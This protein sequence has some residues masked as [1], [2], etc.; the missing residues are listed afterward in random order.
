M[1]LLPISEPAYRRVSRLLLE[2][3]MLPF[4]PA[5]VAASKRPGATPAPLNKTAI[6]HATPKL[7]S[8]SFLALRFSLIM[9]T[10][11]HSSCE[12]KLND[13]RLVSDSFRAETMTSMIWTTTRTTTQNHKPASRRKP[14]RRFGCAPRSPILRTLNSRAQSRT[15]KRTQSGDWRSVSESRR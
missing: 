9:R 8:P 4:F 12:P 1:S 10:M 11:F 6:C 13:T 5:A 7:P 15:R 3:L 14:F 2:D